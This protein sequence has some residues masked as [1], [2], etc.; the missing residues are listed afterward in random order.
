[1]TIPAEKTLAELSVGDRG[2]VCRIQGDDSIT[3][4]LLEMGLTPGVEACLIG[5]AP[6][7]DPIEIEVRNYRLSLRISEARRVIVTDT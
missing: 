7:G 2:C 1:M 4:R 3:T 5:T 6:L